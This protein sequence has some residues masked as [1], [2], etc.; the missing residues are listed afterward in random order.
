MSDDRPFRV[1]PGRIR[2]SKAQRARPFISQA[3][4][5]A[6]GHIRLWLVVAHAL[7]G[8]EEALAEALTR[9]GAWLR[10]RVATPGAA[11]LLW[12]MGQ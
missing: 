5:A 2:S 6:Q 1:R 11:L 10:E 9:R 8:E 12:D 7:P 4:A 3:L